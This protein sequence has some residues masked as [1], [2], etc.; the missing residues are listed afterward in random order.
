MFHFYLCDKPLVIAIPLAI[1]IGYKTFLSHKQLCLHGSSTPGGTLVHNEFNFLTV[2]ST[3]SLEV[4]NTPEK[5]GKGP[6]FES[7]KDLFF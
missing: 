5:E 4:T 6:R 1:A 2:S 3:L 7:D